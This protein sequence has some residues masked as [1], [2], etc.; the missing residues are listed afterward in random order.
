MSQTIRPFLMFQNQDAEAAMTFYVSLFSDGEILDIE[1]YG[2]AG[3]GLEGTVIRARFR[4]GGQEVFVSDSFVKHAFGFTPSSSL[5]VDCASEDE[6]VRL[7]AVLA[8]GGAVLMPLGDYG[9]SKR[10]AWVNDRFGV[11]W[12]LNLA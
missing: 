3:P 5:F 4:V 9:F 12:Q 6:I 10:F 2:A 11:S 1:R 8:E 7:S